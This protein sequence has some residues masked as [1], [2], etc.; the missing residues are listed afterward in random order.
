MGAASLLPS[1]SARPYRYGARIE[2]M[3]RLPIF[4]NLEGRKVIVVGATEAAAW[5][6][7]LA[8]SCGAEVEIFVGHE[9]PCEMLQRLVAASNGTMRIDRSAWT[10]DSLRGSALVIADCTDAGEARHIR[11]E[12]QQMG[13]PCNI[14]DKPEF[15][16]FQFGS[17]VNRS[18]V[19]V[20]ISTDGA[21]PILAQSIR[22]RIESILPIALKDWALLAHRMRREVAARLSPG[23]ARRRFWEAFSELALGR[24]EGP[25]AD[26]VACLRQSMD[27]L[28]H[29]GHGIRGH[30]STVHSCGCGAEM[31]TLGGLRKLQKAEVVVQDEDVRPDVLEL[32]RR[33]A[34]RIV[35]SP[36]SPMQQVQEL[37]D[38]LVDDGK[39]VVRLIART[40]GACACAA[41]LEQPT[42]GVVASGSIAPPLL[43]AAP[44][45]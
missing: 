18:P 34:E 27:R 23:P 25:D 21:A 22:Q 19:I 17:I 6:A 14:I 42:F 2:P 10:S 29:A 35:V 38:G 4:L 5:K 31:L 12:A 44:A 30:L 9:T 24:H 40:A 32:C 20:A 26:D 33:E 13:V 39:Q 11:R 28:P 8:A 1:K 16:D 43:H 3:A 37:L 45:F 36:S 15:C 7:E 41:D